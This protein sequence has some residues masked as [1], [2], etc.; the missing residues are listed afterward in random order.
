[1]MRI[2]SSSSRRDRVPLLSDCIDVLQPLAA[3]LAWRRRL[4][5][6]ER[7]DKGLD[8]YSARG[9]GARALAQSA[10]SD[11]SLD[12]KLIQFKT[13]DVELRLP[14]SRITVAELKV[15]AAASQF[16]GQLVESRLDRLTPWPPALV[17]YGYSLSSAASR[18][19]QCEVLVHATS[20]QIVEQSVDRL[21]SLGLTAST[22]ASASEPLGPYPAINLL[23]RGGDARR[24][25]SRRRIGASILCA[26]AL[27]IVALLFS[28]YRVHESASRL[29]EIEADLAAS[30]ARLVEATASSPE[31]QRDA[32]LIESKGTTQAKF[33][34]VATLAKIIPDDT[35]LDELDLQSDGARIAGTSTDAPRLI[36]VLEDEGTFSDVK[37][38]APVT[39]QADGRDRFDIT[40][41][42]ASKQTEFQE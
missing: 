10:I 18:D 30:R 20:L 2:A 13:W 9:S 26:W 29:A 33:M 41:T 32:A 11:G 35:Y 38:A 6:V 8:F 3:R 36:K 22:V 24:R 19:G 31:R 39:R 17:A 16:T 42:L 4:I 25:T 1:M 21:S 15:P 14:A 40:A 37:F 5:V 7:E 12:R 23:Q 27:S 28:A 34:I